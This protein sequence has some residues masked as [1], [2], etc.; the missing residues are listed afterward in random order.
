MTSQIF[1]LRDFSTCVLLL[2]LTIANMAIAQSAEPRSQPSMIAPGVPCPPCVPV[3]PARPRSAE[4]QQQHMRDVKEKHERTMREAEAQAQARPPQPAPQTGIIAGDVIGEQFGSS[5][6]I[7]NMWHEIVNGDDVRVYAGAMSFD[8]T[9]DSVHY[10]PL[11]VHGF[12][13]VQKGE[14]GGPNM[15]GNKIYTPTAVGSLRI[16]AAKGNVL[17]LQ[18]RQGNKFSLNVETEQLTPLQ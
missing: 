6:R 2:G 9:N 1:C 12:V 8:P 13:I 16:I 15:R 7:E 18:S 14:L 11:T 10:D 17:T 5:H 4:E 3:G